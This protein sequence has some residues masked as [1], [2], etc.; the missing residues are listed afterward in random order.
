MPAPLAAASGMNALAHCAEALWSARRNPMTSALA[1]EGARRLLGSLPGAVD[2][3][4]DVEAHAEN[5][6][7]ACLAGTALAQT[8]TGVHHRTCH[9]LA[10]DWGLPHA[11]THAVV[12]PWAAALVTA[13]EPDAAQALRSLLGGGGGLAT[14][15]YALA[16]RLDLPSSLRELGLP[17]ADVDEA[18]R[19]VVEALRED[20]VGSDADAVRRMVVGA[21]RGE[22]PA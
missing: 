6:L 22:A 13:C 14:A 11:Q 21:W 20:P 1:A 10:G 12:L 18:V 15:L 8:G 5:L 16:R 3:P 9:V 7:G 4:N 2:D 19:R 17:E